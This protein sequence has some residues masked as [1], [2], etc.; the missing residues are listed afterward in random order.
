[1]SNFRNILSNKYVKSKPQNIVT[2]KIVNN[3]E[4]CGELNSKDSTQKVIQLTKRFRAT[5]VKA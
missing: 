1:M 3:I 5:V 2:A 4:K